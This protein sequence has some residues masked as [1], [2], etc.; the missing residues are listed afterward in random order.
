MTSI[1]SFKV[2][3]AFIEEIEVVVKEFFAPEREQG[4]RFKAHCCTDCSN[5]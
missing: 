5:E 2:Q 4:N 1:F 3:I